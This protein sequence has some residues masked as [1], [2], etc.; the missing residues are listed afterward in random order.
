MTSPSLHAAAI[1]SCVGD[2]S[3]PEQSPA[4]SRANLC[5]FNA[6]TATP[7]SFATATREPSGDHATARPKP[8]GRSEFAPLATFTSRSFRSGGSTVGSGVGAGVAVA[9]GV[10]LPAAVEAADGG[11]GVGSL[12]ALFEQAAK[13]RAAA[14]AQ[15][16]KSGFLMNCF[17]CGNS[18]LAAYAALPS[19]SEPLTVCR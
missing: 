8:T 15:I 14:S 17:R 9:T 10:G 18:R 12:F 16:A 7:P 3:A 13:D 1:R 6:P 11:V 2:Q 4:Q 5:A 19:R